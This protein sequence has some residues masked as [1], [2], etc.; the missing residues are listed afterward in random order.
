MYSFEEPKRK[1]Y[2]RKLK[3][4]HSRTILFS[5]LKRTD[6]CDL[7]VD[8]WSTLTHS[9][10]C[11]Q[12]R[13]VRLKN[14]ERT[15]QA[16]A[17]VMLKTVCFMRSLPSFH[18]LPTLDQVLILRSRWVPLF[19]LG[20][21]QERVTFEVTGFPATSFL[22]KILLQDQNKDTEHGPPNLAAVQ[23]LRS[24]LDKLWRLDLTPKEYAYLKGTILFNPGEINLEFPIQ[25]HTIISNIAANYF[26]VIKMLSFEYFKYV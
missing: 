13:L 17:G 1:G 26:I 14:P 20:L 4:E 6:S 10:H 5:I 12:R 21:A 23:N 8:D 18:H 7:G 19:V 3:K 9:C 25:F 22:R 2:S 16:A 11:E 15:C 24:C